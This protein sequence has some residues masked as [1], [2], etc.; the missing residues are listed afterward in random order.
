MA[1][2][3][4]ERLGKACVR[5]HRVRYMKPCYLLVWMLFSWLGVA[6]FVTVNGIRAPE[7]QV[8]AVAY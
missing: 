2:E 3:H 1:F 8:L 4:K 7:Y 6:V 5:R